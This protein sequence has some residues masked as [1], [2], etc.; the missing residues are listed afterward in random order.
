MGLCAGV[1][2]SR[3]VSPN[4]PN[5]VSFYHKQATVYLFQGK[6]DLAVAKT[7]KAVSLF[8]QAAAILD[9]VRGHVS[10]LTGDLSDAER[11]YQNLP[12]GSQSRRTNMAN[13]Y[14]LQGKFEEAKKLFLKNPVMTE[15][16][17]YLYLRR[18]Q[19]REALNELEKVLQEARKAESFSWQIRTMAAKG[20]AFLR[21]KAVE[22]A[23]KVADEIKALAQTG[24]NKKNVRYHLYLMAM[25]ELERR[26]FGRAVSHLTQAAD[27]LYAPNEG[28]PYIQAWFINA[29]AQA[30]YEAAN[31]SKAREE[32]EKI[33]F[34]HIARLQYGD[35]YAQSLY[36]LGKI[37][38]QQG[39]QARAAE[40]FRKFLDLWKN[41]DPGLPEV[42]DAGKRLAGLK[43][44]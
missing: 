6:Y 38:E 26:N 3:T 11:R 19:P 16:L 43:V 39:D 17:A 32:Y 12:E 20:L 24:L 15:P 40:Y 7:E 23:L 9:L 14:V 30:H 22:D 18:G 42:E 28:L 2:T 37:A 27:S 25:I 33:G 1:A 21:M 34:L 31:L 10:L 5:T 35:F 29:L 8:P 41:A 13:L 36:M 44:D 4:K